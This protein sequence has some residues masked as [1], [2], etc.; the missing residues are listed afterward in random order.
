MLFKQ[1]AGDADFTGELRLSQEELPHSKSGQAM[2][3]AAQGS[4]GVTT[5][6]GVQRMIGHGT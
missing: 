3:W 4:D 1:N 2:E 5:P 6:G